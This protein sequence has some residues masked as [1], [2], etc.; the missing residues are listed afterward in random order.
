[1]SAVISLYLYLMPCTIRRINLVPRQ[2]FRYLYVCSSVISVHLEGGGST[3][4][5][6]VSL[7]NA[8]VVSSLVSVAGCSSI[9]WLDEVGGRW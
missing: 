9:P 4:G 6:R 3:R 8:D 5:T 7:I 1:M 2:R